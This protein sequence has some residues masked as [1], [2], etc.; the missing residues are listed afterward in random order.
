MDLSIN[1]SETIRVVDKVGQ[2]FVALVE[3]IIEFVILVVTAGFRL[4]VRLFGVSP[5][6][7]KLASTKGHSF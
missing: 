4:I 2:I 7:L 5:P 1:V 6:R 3:R